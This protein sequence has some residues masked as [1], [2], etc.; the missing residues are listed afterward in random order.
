[1]PTSPALSI[2]FAGTPEFASVALQTLLASHHS[3]KAVYTQPDRPSGRGKKIL[4]SPVK[5]LALQHNLLVRQLATL[6]DVEAQQALIELQADILVVVAYG[7][8]LPLAVLN[9]TRYGA[10]NIHG[11]LLP[12]WR[13]AAPI[14]R[15]IEA[16]DAITGVTIMQLDV[17]LDTGDMLLTAT[18]PINETDTSA[19]IFNQL[20]ELGAKAMLSTLDQIALGQAKPVKQAHELATYAH[21][22]TKEEAKIDWSKPAYQL[23]RMIRAFNPWPIAFTHVDQTTVRVWEADVLATESSVSPGTI[24]DVSNQGIVI[25]TAEGCLRLQKL[26]LP[27]GRVL[28]ISDILNSRQQD[29]G[30]GKLLG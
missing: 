17:G 12:K 1:V 15:S 18:C 8:I 19:S 14:Q 2:I 11:S 9:A 26:Q 30:V 22:I 4:A 7:L 28:A 5:Q 21:K 24:L 16:G 13:G 27:G 3:I 20:S 23:S 29:F 10:I 6:K 25:A